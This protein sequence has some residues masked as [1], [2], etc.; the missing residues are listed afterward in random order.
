M[1]KFNSYFIF[2]SQMTR[3]KLR[4]KMINYKLVELAYQNKLEARKNKL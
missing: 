1:F 3:I 4:E 2:Q